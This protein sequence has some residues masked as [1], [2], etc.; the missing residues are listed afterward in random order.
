MELPE[1]QSEGEEQAP[2]NRT[3]IMTNPQLSAELINGA[4]ETEPD[5]EGDAA[6]LALIREAYI[7]EAASI[8][9]VPV[10]LEVSEHGEN[11][12]AFEGLES[13][14]DK[15]GE[16]LA[17]ERQGT[18]LYETALQKCEALVIQDEVGP[19][20]EELQHI[21]NE[22]LE[23][24]KLLQKAIIKLGGDATLQTPSADVAG[25]LALGMVQVVSDPRTTVPQ[26]LQALL[27][28]E[29]V[30]NDG[31]QLLGDLAAELGQD[32]LEEQCRKALEE[33]QEHLEKVREGVLSMAMEEAAVGAE[34]EEEGEDEDIA[35]QV[36][37]EQE[38]K[39]RKA[40]SSSSTKSKKKPKKE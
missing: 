13:L 32:E 15:L 12:G 7:T 33:E 27:T 17:F 24:F 19:S 5:S 26:M 9:S 30:D 2:V 8:G 3:G 25:I 11:A 14:L 20:I 28:A 29:L 23:H 36:G 10:V 37:D 35:D 4:E 16:R 39:S 31:W 22:E 40:K 6:D 18:R 38:S 21:C 34:L 1:M